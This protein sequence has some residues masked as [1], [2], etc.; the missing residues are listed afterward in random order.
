MC[1][2]SVNPATAVCGTSTENIP[3][4]AFAVYSGTT[5]V[6]HSYSVD[7]KIPHLTLDPISTDNIINAGEHKTD[8]TVTGTTDA[9]NGQTV[10]VNV[11]LYVARVLKIFP[12]LLLQCSQLHLH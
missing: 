7:I 6:D 5:T 12:L 8:L 2:P 1:C 11:G 4:T 9:G 10:T 3:P